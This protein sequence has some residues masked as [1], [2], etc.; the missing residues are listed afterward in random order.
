MIPIGYPGTDSLS[1]PRIA[2]TGRSRGVSRRK[3]EADE[4][5]DDEKG[6]LIL[7]YDLILRYPPPHFSFYD[8]VPIGLR[9]HLLIVWL[10]DPANNFR[11]TN[12]LLSSTPKSLTISLPRTM[13]DAGKI[14]NEC[15]N[16]ILAIVFHQAPINSPRTLILISN[17]ELQRCIGW[18]YVMLIKN[19]L[20]MRH[21]FYFLAAIDSLTEASKRN[22]T[23][24]RAWKV[25]GYP[26][27]EITSYLSR[28]KFENDES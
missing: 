2:G 20:N 5:D 15:L 21:G 14:E 13:S 22:I 10:V 7:S 18:L 12:Q 11:F 6:S 17:N 26:T 19:L 1:G 25:L 4:S 3:E 24:G 28:N 16:T 27:F 23:Y 8:P 9:E